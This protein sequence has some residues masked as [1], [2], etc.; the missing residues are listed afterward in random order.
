MVGCGIAVDDGVCAD[1]EHVRRNI[2]WKQRA[3]SILGAGILA[4]PYHAIALVMEVDVDERTDF[5]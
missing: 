5:T 1:R 3:G 4:A 2:G